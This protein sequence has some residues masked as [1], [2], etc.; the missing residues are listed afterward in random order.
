[1]DR[2]LKSLNLDSA[3]DI[4]TYSDHLMCDRLK[5]NIIKFLSINIVSLFE[6]TYKAQVDQ[7]PQ[8]LLHDL[9]NFIKNK[10]KNKYFWQDLVGLDYLPSEIDNFGSQTEM[11]TKDE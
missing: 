8:Y 6:R 10:D 1:M 4:Y 11:P 7:M 5:V 3:F 9:E 2:I